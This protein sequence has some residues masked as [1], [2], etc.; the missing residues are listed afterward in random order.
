MFILNTFFSRESNQLLINAFGSN[1]YSDKLKYRIFAENET[2]CS[3]STCDHEIWGGNVSLKKY[4]R[5]TTPK[6]YKN[7]AFLT[8]WSMYES[9]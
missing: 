3:R 1:M 5:F 2:F 4:V 7:N 6:M 8:I 9:K